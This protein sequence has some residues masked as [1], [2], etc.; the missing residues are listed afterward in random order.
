MDGCAYQYLSIFSVTPRPTNPKKLKETSVTN[1]PAS[2]QISC[3]S[4]NA[5][6][7]DVFHVLV[8]PS[9]PLWIICNVLVVQL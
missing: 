2:P 6:E 9:V 3:H 4:I 1:I 7:I 8:I 5:S